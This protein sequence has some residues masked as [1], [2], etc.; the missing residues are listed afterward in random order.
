[1]SEV[2]VFGCLTCVTE[3]N[4][5]SADEYLDTDDATNL[6]ATPVGGTWGGA[7]TATGVFNPSTLGVGLYK[8]AYYY[9][10]GDGCE[11]T[12]EKD[13]RVAKCT[14]ATNLALNKF[15]EQDS[16]YADGAANL[17]VDGNTSGN[18]ASNSG[19]ALQHTAGVIGNTI[20]KYPGR[21]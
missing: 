9:S 2:R 1:M 14:A 20:T 3:A 6:T 7:A 10:D 8:V 18:S 16:T 12:V 17:A 19:A 4:I 11:Q 21:K 13:I 15:A 5:S